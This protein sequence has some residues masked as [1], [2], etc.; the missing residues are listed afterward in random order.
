MLR[1]QRDPVA[2]L[3]RLFRSAPPSIVFGLTHRRDGPL[4]HLLITRDPAVARPVLLSRDFRNSALALPAAKGT[5]Q[6]R[7]RKN[8]FR[9]HGDEHRRHQQLIAPHLKKRVV[10]TYRDTMAASIEE[11]ISSW[12]PLQVLDMARE[13]KTLARRIASTT[14]F[15]Q[16]ELRH[17]DRLGESMEQW[18]QMNFRH[19]TRA[20]PRRLPGGP[21]A[22]LLERAEA[23]EQ[24]VQALIQRKRDEGLLGGDLMSRLIAARDQQGGMSEAELVSE[25]HVLFLAAHET[26]A[27]ALT[28]ALFLIAQHPR[29]ADGL[30]RELEAIVGDKD[31]GVEHLDSLDLLTRSI[32]EALRIIPVVP[33]G[34][35][36]AVS[37]T[38][39]GPFD[40]P[41]GSRVLI[42][43]AVMHHR[44]E[45]FP[46]PERFDPDRWLSGEPP[47]Y[48]YLPFSAG[49]H[50]CLGPTFA[51]LT[52]RL[53]LAMILRRFRPRV[54]PGARID[55]RSTVTLA[56]RHGLPMQLFPPDA[57]F[58]RVAVR[59]N[60]LD[61]VD[62]ASPERP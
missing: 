3:D 6:D 41:R 24:Q 50:M 30:V 21:R 57:G 54:V 53:T 34:A 27:Y 5:A 36:V 31:P 59:G 11:M 22:R 47:A 13:M 16:A 52:L 55:R 42:A 18:F 28:W 43:Y 14:L 7:L 48:S 45:I 58:E 20:W 49:P 62:L 40:L 19:R 37:H 8:L 44:P 17:S 38:Q 10:E 46:C 32:D 12:Q 25:L 35:R 26:T 39:V 60:V 56:P 9:L 33:Y 51:I 4:R 2:S 1:F 29:L 15:G 23:I 61:M